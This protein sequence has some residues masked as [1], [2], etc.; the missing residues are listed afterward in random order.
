MLLPTTIFDVIEE[1]DDYYFPP[2]TGTYLRLARMIVT[3]MSLLLTPLFLLYANNPE[4]LPDWLMF[5]KI[6]QPEYVPIFWQ[7]LILE[8]AVDGLKLA[9]INTPSTLN[10]CLLYTS[11]AEF[12]R[13]QLSCKIIG[14]TG[15]VG[16]TSTKEIIASVLK[17][18]FKVLK[19]EGNYNNEIGE[20]LT[21]LKIRD[22]HEVAVIEMG[23][24]DFE[25][26]HRLA[27]VSRP[28]VCVITNIGTCPVSYTHLAQSSGVVF[29]E[30]LI[31]FTRL[32]AVMQHITRLLQ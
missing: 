8:L 11:I 3:V 28:D 16:K 27:K 21:I 10:T 7:L 5:T 19:T 32:K 17:E 1:A 14:I 29:R 4:I 26:M 30:Q 18:K 15:S 20:P 25:E 13:K 9:A 31:M 6:E 22:E 12:Y 24:S 2:V 23:I